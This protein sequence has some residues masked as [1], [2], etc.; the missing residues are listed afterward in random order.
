MAVSIFST[1]KLLS[2]F[3][4][5]H[6]GGQDT[7][8]LHKHAHSKAEVSDMDSA[9]IGCGMQIDL[10]AL[11]LFVWPSTLPVQEGFS[12]LPEHLDIYS[13]LLSESWSHGNDN[14]GLWSRQV[15]ITHSRGKGWNWPLRCIPC[16]E[17]QA[18]IRKGYSS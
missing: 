17:G 1:E 15:G 11:R 14:S 2:V 5:A 16:Q 12:F 3:H 18:G 4:C 8:G 9:I 6:L 13:R 10:A 7:P